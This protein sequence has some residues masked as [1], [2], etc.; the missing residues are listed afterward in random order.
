MSR[1]IVMASLTAAACGSSTAVLD[2]STGSAACKANLEAAIN[3]TCTVPSD[4]VL[5]AS[6]D[7]CGTIDLAV[8]S[9]TEAAFPSVEATYSACLAC[10]P[11]GCLHADEAED[12]SAPG[13]GQSIVATCVASRCTS[14]V[15]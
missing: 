2:A 7:C 5:V 10:P 9:G 13:S 1:A 3:Q 11:S 4:C 15:Q 8:K 14:V 12:G 6:A